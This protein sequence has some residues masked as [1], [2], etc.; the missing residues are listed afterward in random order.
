MKYTSFQVLLLS[1]RGGGGGLGLKLALASETAQGLMKILQRPCLGWTT[2][3]S[4]GVFVQPRNL[5]SVANSRPHELPAKEQQE[6][7][8][9]RFGPLQNPESIRPFR[10]GCAVDDSGPKSLFH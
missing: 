9:H 10:R 3:S 5:H 2:S 7:R 1:P 4:S 8:K 6:R